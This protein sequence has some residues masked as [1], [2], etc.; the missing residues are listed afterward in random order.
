M[1]DST[2]TN[3]AVKEKLRQTESRVDY[4]LSRKVLPVFQDIAKQVYEAGL[5]REP[6]INALGRFALTFFGDL[7]LKQQQLAAQKIQYEQS[8][9][10]PTR[11]PLQQ[12]GGNY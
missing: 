9:H 2:S 7:W 8:L 10:P 5:I 11:D 3:E 4:R 1:N 6:N 12:V